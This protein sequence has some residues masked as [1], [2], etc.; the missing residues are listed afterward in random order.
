M[1][2]VQGCEDRGDVADGGLEAGVDEE[3]VV[4][5]AGD[6]EGGEVGREVAEKGDGVGRRRAGIAIGL[7]EGIGVGGGGDGGDYG[8]GFGE[9]GGMKDEGRR[10]RRRV[11]GGI[12]GF[13]VFLWFGLFGGRF[14]EG[15]F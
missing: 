13:R 8:G 14:V 1:H 3:D 6:G 10:M 11:V 5:G 15:W 12:R 2:E 9:D 7:E 4:G